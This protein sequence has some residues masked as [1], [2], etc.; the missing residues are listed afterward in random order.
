MADHDGSTMARMY[1]SGSRHRPDPDRPGR[2]G[3]RSSVGRCPRGGRGE[4]ACG[5]GRPVQAC[6]LEDRQLVSQPIARVWSS[7]GEAN[8]SWVGCSLEGLPFC[9][10]LFDHVHLRFVGLGIPETAWESLLD[11]CTRVLKSGTGILEVSR[12]GRDH[13]HL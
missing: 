4:S 2:P 8:L 9:S 10:E 13:K 5:L 3:P 12:D 7:V 11:E 6:R 1:R